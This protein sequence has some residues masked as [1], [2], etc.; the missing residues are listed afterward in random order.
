M[1]PVLD[2]TRGQLKPVLADS[3]DVRAQAIQG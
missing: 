2:K 1:K 3:G